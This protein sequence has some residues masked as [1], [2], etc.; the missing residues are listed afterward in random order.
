MSRKLVGLITAAA[1]AVGS[2]VPTAAMAA[3]VVKAP[4]AVDN[5]NLTEAR[6]HHRRYY[7]HRR[8]GNAAGVAAA[9]GILGLAA[10]AAIASQSQAAPGRYYRNDPDWVAYCARKYRSY[11]PYTDTFLAHDGYRYRCR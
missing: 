4:L 2:F 9:A 5:L 7:R 11:D 6:H 3:P 1:L 10:G 8:G